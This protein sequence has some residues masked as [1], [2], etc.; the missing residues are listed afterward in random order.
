M[1]TERTTPPTGG[2]SLFWV[3]AAVIVAALAALVAIATA[4]CF[5]AGTDPITVA[6]AAW[7]FIAT[8]VIRP[9]WNGIT[10]ILGLGA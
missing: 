7:H 8:D 2:P 4:I 6:L 9:A 1:R 3:A 5:A 10:S